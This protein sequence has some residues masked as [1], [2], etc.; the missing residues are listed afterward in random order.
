MRRRLLSGGTAADMKEFSEHMGVSIQRASITRRLTAAFLDLILLFTLAVGFGWLLAKITGLA[1][2]SDTLQAAYDQY[3]AEYGISFDID[4][5]TYDAMNP[6]EKAN[7]DGAYQA[8]I[9]DGEAMRAYNLLNNLML[10]VLTGGVTLSYLVLEFGVPLILKNGQTVGKKVFA[11]AVMRKDGV[12]VNGVQLF[13]RSILG[14]CTV[15]TMLPIYI[16]AL[17]SQLGI[18]G[19]IVLAALGLGQVILLFIGDHALIQDRMANT[20]VVDMNSQ[21]IFESEE[22]LVEYTRQRHAEEAERAEY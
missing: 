2:H 21:R 15:G 3:E 9:S 22:A 1:G 5:S 8:L 20:V 16:V 17:W 10:L 11:M 6:E 4:Q 7:W 18:I 19:T 12:K 14:K 13:I